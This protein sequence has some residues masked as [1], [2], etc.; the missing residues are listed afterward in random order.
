MV[1][2]VWTMK[3]LWRTSLLDL[4]SAPLFSLLMEADLCTS[5]KT[6]GIWWCFLVKG[7]W[8]AVFFSEVL[9]LE[10]L[11]LRVLSGCADGKI[12]IFNYLTGICLRVLVANTKGDPISSFCVGGNRLV[13]TAAISLWTKLGR[14]HC[15]VRN[16]IF[17]P[18]T[19]L[20]TS[21]F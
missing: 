2:L 11:Y 19:V 18:F 15:N 6:R 17:F 16:S 21:K 4:W 9:S 5:S 20:L 13:T 12:R 3:W 1:W 10:F 8:C 7:W 14:L